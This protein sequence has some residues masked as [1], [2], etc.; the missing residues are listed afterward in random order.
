MNDYDDEIDLFALLPKDRQKKIKKAES[1]F[2][3]KII[4]NDELLT[5]ILVRPNGKKAYEFFAKNDCLIDDE[6]NTTG[7]TII[8]LVRE[9]W[10]N[11]LYEKE[12]ISISKKFFVV[13]SIA[14]VSY[15]LG[16]MAIFLVCL[17]ATMFFMFKL[18][19]LSKEKILKKEIMKLEKGKFF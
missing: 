13:L 8:L 14:I 1:I 5:E 19:L 3:N 4:P 17:T 18:N 12:G 2:A 10:K 7:D 11:N 9:Y 6:L 16:L 15:C